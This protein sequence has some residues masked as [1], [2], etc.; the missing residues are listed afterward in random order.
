MMEPLG[1][2]VSLGIIGCPELLPQGEQRIA[3]VGQ[4]ETMLE[5][6]Q[7][8]QEKSPLADIQGVFHGRLKRNALWVQLL[9]G[10]PKADGKVDQGNVDKRQ[11]P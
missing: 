4:C 2:W 11:D 5:H 6:E 3:C 10:S 8:Q 9:L 1:R 7:K